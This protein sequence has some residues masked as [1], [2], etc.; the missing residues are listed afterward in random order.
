V[1]FG[2]AIDRVVFRSADVPFSLLLAVSVGAVASCE[3][4]S[5]WH[6][7]R[8]QFG[9]LAR[10]RLV[11]AIACVIA[12]LSVPLVWLSGPLGLIVGQLAG[13]S[14]ESLVSRR[15]Y[16]R[17]ATKTFR[18]KLRDLRDVAWAYRAYPLFDMWASVARILTVNCPAL[19]LAWA[20][21]PAAA[22]CLLLAQRLLSTP[23]SMLSYSVSRV[24]YSEAAA[25]ARLNPAGL[26]TL[27]VDSLKRLTW[28]AAPPLAIVCVLA[29]WTFDIVFGAR[30]QS[31]GVYCSLLC[32]LV[33]LRMISFVL[34]P[35]F[36]AAG[37]QGLRLLREVTCLA[38]I[39]S[40]VVVASWL[41]WSA[42]AAVALLS[43]LGSAG[44]LLALI[45][46]WST[47]AGKIST[48]VAQTE[49]QVGQQAA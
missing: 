27:F 25:L 44:Y 7:R 30:W 34:G 45:A 23:L 48:V 21:G 16:G 33:L 37:R 14:T 39:A 43:G 36:D 47:V 24:Y 18:T 10:M 2:E 20:Y 9:E 41:G 8:G 26:P 40:G 17:A 15:N 35:T 4:H 6:M 29:P 5:A 3:I 19:L 22:G 12:Q 32:P 13:Y 38:L 28:L 1:L 49:H 42:V 31:A 11:Q 46:A